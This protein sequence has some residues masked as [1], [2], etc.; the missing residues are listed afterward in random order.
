MGEST[1]YRHLEGDT[2]KCRD[3]QERIKK[4]EAE[5]ISRNVGVIQVAAQTTWTASAWWLERRYARDFGRKD[6]LNVTRLEANESAQEVVQE[7]VAIIHANVLDSCPHC[8]SL[9]DQKTRIAQ[10]LNEV[11]KKYAPK[12]EKPD[13]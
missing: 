11:A 9:L 5:A 4:A 3:F 1:F 8:K 10:Q 13:S 6:N 2:K 12:D 7:L